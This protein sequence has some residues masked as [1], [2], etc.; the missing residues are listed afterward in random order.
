MGWSLRSGFGGR[1][2]YLDPEDDVHEIN[3]LPRFRVTCNEF[4]CLLSALRVTASMI[5]QIVDRLGLI[6]PGTARFPLT[7]AP[8]SDNKGA[9]LL[10]TKQRWFLSPDQKVWS[11]GSGDRRGDNGIVVVMPHTEELY[12]ICTRCKYRPSIQYPLP[13]TT[14]RLQA[15][16]SGIGP[17]QYAVASAADDTQPKQTGCAAIS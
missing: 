6:D 16:Q 12:G 9:A 5:L 14:L 8:H 13:S 4:L 15:T 2:G 1:S 10:S 3:A 17:R 11:C 7:S